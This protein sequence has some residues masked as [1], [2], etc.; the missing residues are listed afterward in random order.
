MKEQFTGRFVK[1]DKQNLTDEWAREVWRHHDDDGSFTARFF[2]DDDNRV[3]LEVRDIDHPP[4]WW[5]QWEKMT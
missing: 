3:I 2:G 5:E 1:T 4:V